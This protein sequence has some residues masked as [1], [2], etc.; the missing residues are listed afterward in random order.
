[1]AALLVAFDAV[2][3]QPLQPLD[4]SRILTDELINLAEAFDNI[5]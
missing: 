1:M 3:Y 4:D 2:R 5:M